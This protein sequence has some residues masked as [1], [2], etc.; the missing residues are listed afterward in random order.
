MFLFFSGLLAAL[1]GGIEAAFAV[2]FDSYFW[3]L[4]LDEMLTRGLCLYLSPIIA[5]FA[6]PFFT[7]RFGKKKQLCT[8][9]LF[10]FSLLLFL[11]L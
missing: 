6:A 2:Y 4:N 8:S 10:K 9:G 3:G 7:D 11:L 5:I 1:A